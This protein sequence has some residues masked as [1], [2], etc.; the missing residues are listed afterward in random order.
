MSIHV[1]DFDV[2][3]LEVAL[4]KGEGPAHFRETEESGKLP[5]GWYR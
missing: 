5:H 1:D 3:G 2:D 4:L